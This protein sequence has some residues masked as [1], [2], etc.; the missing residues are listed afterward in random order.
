MTT[1]ESSRLIFG[2]GLLLAGL[3]VWNSKHSAAAF[4]TSARIAS[5]V[6]TLG[7]RQRTHIVSLAQLIRLANGLLTYFPARPGITARTR[8]RCFPAAL[9]ARAISLST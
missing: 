5:F 9:H 3:E 2:T 1:K 4:S 6:R 7:R 8:Q